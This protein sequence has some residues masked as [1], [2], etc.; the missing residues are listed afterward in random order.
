M[1]GIKTHCVQAALTGAAIAP[2][3]SPV[4]TAAVCL[5]IVLIDVDH[6]IEY[7]RQTGSFRIWGVFPCCHIIQSNLNRGF[8]VLNPFHTLEFMLLIATLG[9]L[10]PVFF[11][12]LAGAL[13]HLALDLFV[14][15]RRKLPFIR[16]LSIVEYLVRIR[17]PQNIVRFHDL[18]CIDGFSLPQDRWN[19]P[20]WIRHWQHCR[21]L[22]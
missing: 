8:F 22:F 15:S 14:L 4:N 3:T 10:Q 19:Y 21:P 12:V 17:N 7:V 16:A 9:L 2:F 11:Y 13:W 5:S 18:L 1:P 20:F 6:V